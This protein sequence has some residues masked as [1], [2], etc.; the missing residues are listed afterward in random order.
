MEDL[1]EIT[2]KDFCSIIMSASHIRTSNKTCVSF[3]INNDLITK[4]THFINDACFFDDWKL[5]K[6]MRKKSSY[7]EG[8][9]IRA[10]GTKTCRIIECNGSNHRYYQK[11]SFLVDE[12]RT[13][14]RSYIELFEFFHFKD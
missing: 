8:I 12:I 11:E 10:V 1:K 14:A 9:R 13:P 2:P 5:Y 7:R 3:E 6:V 4:I